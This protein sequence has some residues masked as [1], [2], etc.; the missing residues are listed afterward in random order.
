MLKNVVYGDSNKENLVWH[1]TVLLGVALFFIYFS[2]AILS[3]WVPGFLEKSLG[4]AT[5]MGVI[6]GCSSLVGLAADM[7][8][9][10]ML[11]GMK[12]R[13]LILWAVVTGWVFGLLLLFTT[14]WPVVA[15][16]LLAMAVWGI[17]YE[18]LGFG[19]GLFVAN[20]I[21][22]KQ[23]SGAWAILSTFKSLAY[24]LGPFMAGRLLLVGNSTLLVAAFFVAFIGFAI[25]ALVGNR[26]ERAVAYEVEA[27]Q[28]SLIREMGHWWTLLERVW[29]VLVLS[30]VLGVVDATFWT[31]GAVYTETLAQESWWGQWF[32]PMYTLPSLF[33][34][35]AVLKWGI[36]R[37]KKK[38]AEQF[39]LVGGVFLIMMWVSSDIIWLLGMVTIASVLMS[40]AFP[41]VDA[42]YTDIS[43]R[44]GRERKHMIGLSQST[45]S[46]AYIAGPIITGFVADKVGERMTFV[47]L[48]IGV[49][50]TAAY[51]L[52][53]TPKK[54]K[55]PQTEIERW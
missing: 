23:R 14:W 10:Q 44:M 53:V 9:P 19:R 33:V 7:L 51:L 46:L 8:L 21:P 28:I 34:G 37:G 20:Y 48:G 38:L 17:Y 52:V 29:P 1:R 54:L 12:V 2:D 45:I 49:V 30:L 35:F 6:F 18:L 16:M 42:V 31:T 24:F 3:Y 13:S 15:L 4:S 22:N 32:L 25:Y 27:S 47:V 5:M 39:L 50:I 43:V 40:V 41:L 11:R 26:K 55:L 36:F